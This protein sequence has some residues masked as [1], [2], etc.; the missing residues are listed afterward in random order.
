[1]KAITTTACVCVDG[2]VQCLYSTR[3]SVSRL[4]SLTCHCQP[5]TVE[6]L[7]QVDRQHVRMQP[8]WPQAKRFH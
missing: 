7:A 4:I 5:K 6:S 1:V 8:E 3:A 2:Y